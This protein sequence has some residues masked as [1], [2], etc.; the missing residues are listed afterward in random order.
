MKMFSVYDSKAESFDRPFFLR[1]KGEALRGWID[2]VN[3]PSTQFNKHSA[4]FTLFELGEF[5]QTTGHVMLH[6][7]KISLG[8][9]LEHKRQQTT[10]MEVVQ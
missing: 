7:A 4:D 9:A 5:D 6:E 1:T 10:T 8:T 3:D 2:V